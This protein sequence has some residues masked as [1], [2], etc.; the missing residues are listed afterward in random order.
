MDDLP[1]ADSVGVHELSRQLRRLVAAS[2]DGGAPVLV[3]RRHHSVALLVSV[4]LGLQQRAAW[5]PAQVG[6]TRL[7]KELSRI[8]KGVEEERRAVVITHHRRP[9]AMLVP[10]E[11]PLMDAYRRARQDQLDELLRQVE[12]ATQ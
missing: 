12:E 6:M 11:G 9:R 2:G 10:A 5:P 7:M 8:L 3:T 4:E 1:V